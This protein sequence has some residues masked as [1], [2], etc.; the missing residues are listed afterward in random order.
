M[1][2]QKFRPLPV[3]GLGAVLAAGLWLGGCRGAGAVVPD[4]GARVRD[5]VLQIGGLERTYLVRLPPSYEASR[6]WPLV[7]ALHGGG[8]RG[9]DMERLTHLG[10]IADRRGFVVVYPDGYWRRWADGRGTTPPERAGVDDVAFVAALLDELGRSLAIDPA[11][12]YATGISNGGFFANR[13]ACELA[14]RIAAVA[15]VAA[16]IGESL[17]ARCRPSRPVPVL[18]IHGARDPLVP[19]DGGEMTVGA[20][21]RI[22][23]APATAARWAGLDGCDPAPAVTALPARAADGTSVRREAYGGCRGGVEVLLY[24]IEGGGHAWPGGLQYLPER[25]IGKTN[26]DLDAGEVI[27]EFF[28]RHAVR[29]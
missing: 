1:T 15:A 29:P 3:L 14:G 2:G 21:G 28:E 17:A 6:R 23:S 7:L 5:G 9:R 11:R 20:G 8:G 25:L 27:M 12:V 26:R 13:L 24:A 10:E 22:L 16:T 19:W 18:I 4:G